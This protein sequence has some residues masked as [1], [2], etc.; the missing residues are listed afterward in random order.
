MLEE[1]AHRWGISVR[2]MSRVANNP[3]QRDLDAVNGLPHKNEE[4]SEYWIMQKKDREK[5]KDKCSL[6]EDEN[7]VIKQEIEPDASLADYDESGPRH[8]DLDA[9]FRV[10]IAKKNS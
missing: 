3:K 9:Q 6:N 8:D 1:L 2:Q 7:H 5:T 4:R 10:A